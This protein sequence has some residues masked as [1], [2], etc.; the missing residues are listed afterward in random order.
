MTKINFKTGSEAL[1]L[2]HS[3]DEKDGKTDGK[4]S[5]SVWN[6]FVQGKGGKT[7]QYSITVENA[8]KSI[9]TY[10]ARNSQSTGKSKDEL[11]VNWFTQNSK[12]DNNKK[13][14]LDLSFLEEQNKKNALKPEVIEKNANAIADFVTGQKE[15]FSISPYNVAQVFLKASEKFGNGKLPPTLG[16]S[17]YL[18]SLFPALVKKANELGISTYYKE[19]QRFENI[20]EKL[21]ACR[22]LAYKITEKENGLPQNTVI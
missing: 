11:L 2:A 15:S 1:I 9:S 8:A 18:V 17:L 20:D 13:N 10:L 21:A 6:K 5:A 12:V 7:I 16:T 19:N 22:D 4:I 3:L 14:T